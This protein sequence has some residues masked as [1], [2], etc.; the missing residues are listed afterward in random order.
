MRPW[1]T[2]QINQACRVL[3]T[4]VPDSIGAYVK[5]D[6]EYEPLDPSCRSIRLQVGY[7][8][9]ESLFIVTGEKW[10]SELLPVGQPDC[11]GGGANDFVRHITG[12]G[13]VHAVNICLDAGT[14]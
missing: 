14:K 12:V 5:G 13:F 3:L 10:G 9:R 8:G 4:A 6:R 7:Q 1:T 11:G 2:D